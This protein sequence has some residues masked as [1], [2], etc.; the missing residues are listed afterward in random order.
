MKPRQTAMLC[1]L[2]SWLLILSACNNK[3]QLVA[4][5]SN[6][7]QLD[8]Q[9]NYVFEN[10]T[11]RISYDFFSKN[12]YLRFSIFNKTQAPIYVHWDRS[13]YI[14][15][16]NYL[17]YYQDQYVTNGLIY[18]AWYD[19]DSYY[20]FGDAIIHAVA[21]RG[22]RLTFIPPNA[23]LF[24]FEFLIKPGDGFTP[25]QLRAGEKSI[26][27][28]SANKENNIVQYAFTEQNA[29]IRFRNYLS[30]STDQQGLSSFFIENRFWIS[31]VQEADGR[32]FFGV[33]YEGY[34]MVDDFVKQ[35][36]P[37]RKPWPM[38]RNH[39]VL[40]SRANGQNQTSPAGIE[41]KQVEGAP[42]RQQQ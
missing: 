27:R 12:G 35:G 13:S 31:K 22:D 1:M 21:K 15:G 36:V 19:W 29:P 32:Q 6:S 24:Q 30:F 9:R 14:V 34:Y 37:R 11:L 33:L 7:V 4:L 28:G 18:N 26:V 2:F 39:F 20:G 10:D 16:T 38:D 41:R 3:I 42:R 5:S 23:E 8:E 25:G 40:R 17:N